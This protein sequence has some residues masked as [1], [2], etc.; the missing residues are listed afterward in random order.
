LLP[1]RIGPFCPWPRMKTIIWSQSC[2]HELQGQRCKN[3]HRKH[4]AF[5]EYSFSVINR[6]SLLQRWRCSCKFKSRRIGSWTTDFI[7]VNVRVRSKFF[8][9]ATAAE[10]VWTD[11]KFF[12][13][14]PSCHIRPAWDVL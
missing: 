1:M 6:S 10:K 2:D 9:S 7:T 13:S 8:Y 4:S 5:L 3:S 11:F 14:C 12:A